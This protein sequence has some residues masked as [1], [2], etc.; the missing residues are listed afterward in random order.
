MEA[1]QE[2]V[3]LSDE[4]MEEVTGGSNIG[5]ALDQDFTPP[6]SVVAL[7]SEDVPLLEVVEKAISKA[8]DFKSVYRLMRIN[9][10]S[11]MQSVKKAARIVR[12]PYLDKLFE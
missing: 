4:E 9:G 10:D 11:R 7:G 12:V 1:E 3:A 2:S 8:S 6:L 5:Y